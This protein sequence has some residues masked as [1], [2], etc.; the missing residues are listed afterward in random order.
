MTR[1]SLG[2]HVR[3]KGNVYET[4]HSKTGIL[5]YYGKTHF[6]PGNWA[7]VELNTKEGKND[8]SVDGIRYFSCEDGYGLFVDISRISPTDDLN[9]DDV[10]K[11]DVN[12]ADPNKDEVNN[13]STLQTPDRPI[14]LTFKSS[15]KSRIIEELKTRIMEKDEECIL[16]VEAIRSE[17]E[18]E[19]LSE[20]EKT[21]KES[22]RADAIEEKLRETDSFIESLNKEIDLLHITLE[23]KE[24]KDMEQ[25]MVLLHEKNSEIKQLKDKISDLKDG[26]DMKAASKDKEILDLNETINNLDIE[27]CNYKTS[28]LQKKYDELNE[29][30]EKQKDYYENLLQGSGIKSNPFIYPQKT[31]N[32]GSMYFFRYQKQKDIIK[33]MADKVQK[34]SIENEILKKTPSE[35]NRNIIRKIDEILDTNILASSNNILNVLDEEFRMLDKNVDILLEHL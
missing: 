30:Y 13:E 5:R 3:I 21:A 20:K 2:T 9:K 27:I 34:L 33:E 35:N 15:R 17:L 25:Q 8:G 18:K 14:N 4:N 19:L 7:G 12:K 1:L 31:D 11:D 26:A 24:T 32:N 6:R 22:K 16:Q 29:A 10:N 23:G 28:D